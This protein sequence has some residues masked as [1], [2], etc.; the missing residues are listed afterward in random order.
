MQRAAVG[1]IISGQSKWKLDLRTSSDQFYGE[2]AFLPL[3]Y[4]KT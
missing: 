2:G 3:C 1:N 4:T